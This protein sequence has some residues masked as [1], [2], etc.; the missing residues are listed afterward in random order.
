MVIADPTSKLRAVVH[1]GHKEAV[2]QIDGFITEIPEDMDVLSKFRNNLKMPLKKRKGLRD[3]ALADLNALVNK[4]TLSN[5]KKIVEKKKIKGLNLLA[6][7]GGSWTNELFIDGRPQW[8][9]KVKK[10]A[11]LLVK[12]PIP[13][14]FRFREDILW[15]RYGQIPHAQKWKLRL[16]AAHRKERKTREKLNALRNKRI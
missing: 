14:D 1:F 10:F 6:E 15:L 4:P 11:Y 13:S 16:E 7:I 2:D 5:F 8:N 9:K 12:D 3:L